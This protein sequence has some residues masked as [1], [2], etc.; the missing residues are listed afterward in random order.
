MFPPAGGCCCDSGR[1]LAGLVVGIPLR[2]KDSWS[3]PSQAFRTPAETCRDL[4]LTSHTHGEAALPSLPYYNRW[5]QVILSATF[6]GW[7]HA[8]V[9]LGL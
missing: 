2:L 3:C 1:P 6:Q 9:P 4:S 5:K 8:R 7:D